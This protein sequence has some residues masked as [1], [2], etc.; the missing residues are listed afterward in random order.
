MLYNLLYTLI[1]LG[2][3]DKARR[4]IRNI[5]KEM[6]ITEKVLLITLIYGAFLETIFPFKIFP[7]V[8]RNTMIVK[9]IKLWI[10]L[11]RKFMYK[12]ISTENIVN[13]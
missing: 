11:I 13:T 2:W 3:W 1:R 9:T 8:F 10:P 5:G 7:R 4:L 12:V 6:L